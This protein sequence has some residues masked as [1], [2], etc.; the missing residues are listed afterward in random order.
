MNTQIVKAEDFGLEQKT[1]KEISSKF[2][3]AI[4]ERDGLAKIYGELITKE[5]TPGLVGQARE[6]RLKLVK[7]RTGIASIHK[8]Q[9]D[10]YLA[11]GRFVDA[12]KNKETL[13]V[14]QMEE[15]LTEIEKHFENLELQRIE[16][17]K[18][19]R[20]SELEK[21]QVEELPDNLGTMSEDAFQA[22]LV[23]FR[24]MHEN[25]IAE[26]KKIEEERIE[27]ER[28]D[29]LKTA[30]V[31]EL[32]PYKE[33]VTDELDLRSMTED[34]Y[35]EVLQAGQALKK[36]QDEEQERVRV[37]NEKLKKEAD[38]KEAQEEK[39][40]E[41]RED[42]QE[43]L[44]PYIIFIRDYNQMIELPEH[45]Y[46]IALSDIHKGAE[47]HA[48]FEVER[49][50]KESDEKQALEDKIKANEESEEKAKEEEENRLKAGDSEQFKM[51]MDNLK[52]AKITVTMKSKKYQKQA[53][54]VN[55][56]IDKIINHINK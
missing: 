50:K 18:V 19:K 10:F 9:K 55:I 31:I 43:E 45:E 49:L 54:E 37:E 23:G 17:I 39:E 33:F 6:L 36:E 56:L 30:R 25:K 8:T 2:T 52:D 41:I 11:G 38:E 26:A 46:Q 34:V 24:T 20:E 22:L 47:Q 1:A 51:C 42:R 12:W 16:K 5:L 40:K 32:A 21:Y 28:L 53:E 35:S 15:K 48:K 7:V 13:P 27:N 3:P 29:K 44:K 4:Q 14:T